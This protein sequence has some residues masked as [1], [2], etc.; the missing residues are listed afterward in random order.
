MQGSWSTEGLAPGVEVATFAG[1]CFWSVQLA[2]DRVE[3][4][5]RTAVGYAQGRTS[6]PTY[7]EVGTGD[8]AVRVA[9]LGGCAVHG[10]ALYALSAGWD[11]LL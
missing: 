1:G 3:G 2:F 7:E 11:H 5:V 4:V 6:N 8:C 10:S 9:G